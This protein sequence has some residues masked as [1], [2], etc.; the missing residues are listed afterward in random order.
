MR[1]RAGVK[2]YERQSFHASVDRA[3]ECLCQIF[4]TGLPADEAAGFL[5]LAIRGEAW[6]VEFE[7]R[8]LQPTVV[9]SAKP[10]PHADAVE[11]HWKWA[12]CKEWLRLGGVVTTQKQ[13][14]DWAALL[15]DAHSQSDARD[16][17][18]EEL[19]STAG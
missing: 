13:L 1:M 5:A 7:A 12:F 2:Q 11:I 9:R 3:G 10:A 15:Y 14:G 19:A 18:R 6:I 16:V 4:L 17:A 8:G